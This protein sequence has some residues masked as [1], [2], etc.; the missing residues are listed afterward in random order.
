MIDKVTVNDIKKVAEDIFKPE[1][2]N[3][4]VMGG[5]RKKI[6]KIPKAIN[7]MSQDNSLNNFVGNNSESSFSCF[8]FVYFLSGQNYHPLVFLC[9]DNIAT[10]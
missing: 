10:A 3:L 2:L 1:K 6:K 7:I 4:A 9:F 5:F 8:C